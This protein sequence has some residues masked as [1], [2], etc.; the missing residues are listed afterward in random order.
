MRI[1]SIREW[2]HIPTRSLGLD[3]FWIEFRES[4]QVLME[5]L[6]LELV[7]VSGFGEFADQVAG[8]IERSLALVWIGE[9]GKLF[10]GH[11]LEVGEG[12]QAGGFILQLREVGEKTAEA[13]VVLGLEHDF[14]HHLRK[15]RVW[16]GKEEADST[17][18]L[19]KSI[20]P[21]CNKGYK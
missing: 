13:A 3:F 18:R 12:F 10:G 6:G 5:W 9:S 20:R 15:P 16:H 14:F 1:V 8:E 11:A 21:P 17:P 2:I 7:I 19:G 4:L